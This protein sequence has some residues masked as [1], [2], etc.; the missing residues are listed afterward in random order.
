[1][2]QLEILILSSNR[3]RSSVI[4]RIQCDAYHIQLLKTPEGY[5]FDSAFELYTDRTYGE[6]LIRIRK[7]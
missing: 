1:M 6:W 4:L 7:D 5:S 3:F 2:L